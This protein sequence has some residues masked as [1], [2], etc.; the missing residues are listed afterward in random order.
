MRHALLRS[1]ARL[2]AGLPVRLAA[3][4]VGLLALVACGGSGSRPVRREAASGSERVS[5]AL[6]GAY[7]VAEVGGGPILPSLLDDPSC[8]AGRALFTFHDDDTVS[9]AIETACEGPAQQET[10]CS[11]ELTTGVEWQGAAFRVP[12][13]VRA[14]GQVTQ[15][16][17][18]EEVPSTDVQDTC[19]VGLTPMRW[20]IAERGPR[21]V[22]VNEHGDRMVLDPDPDGDALDWSA[23][24]RRARTRRLAAGE[25]RTM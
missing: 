23:V 2:G 13:T 24:T 9:F 5:P 14:R 8:Y 12:V 7:R 3:A 11:A 6:Q 16:T 21:V 20:R 10:V 17:H 22:L 15:F 19:E 1:W 25:P 18:A 4:L